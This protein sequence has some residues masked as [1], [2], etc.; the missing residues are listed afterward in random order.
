METN[1]TEV[2]D[3]FVVLKKLCAD[4]MDQ[5][6]DELRKLG[7]E[8]TSVDPDD[9]VVEGTLPADKLVDVKSCKC[10]EAVRIDF[11]YISERF[12]QEEEPGE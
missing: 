9:G 6:A 12:S 7:M 8:I 4:R 1:E 10:V 2:S 11:T 5:S 3:I